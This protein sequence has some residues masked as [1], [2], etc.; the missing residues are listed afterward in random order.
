MQKVILGGDNEICR[1]RPVLASYGA[2]ERIDY[3]WMYGKAD[4]FGP[5]MASIGDWARD[6]L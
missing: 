2:A 4:Q 5:D 1:N 6:Q 3:G